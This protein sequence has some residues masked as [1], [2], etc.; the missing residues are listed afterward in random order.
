MSASRANAGAKNRRAGGAGLD[1]RPQQ[2]EPQQ[3]QQP[4]LSISDAIG[5]ITLRLGRVENV[6]QH[7]QTDLPKSEAT[8]LAT[9]T[10]YV[11]QSAFTAITKRLEAIEQKQK[12]AIVPAPVLAPAPVPFSLPE[13]LVTRETVEKLENELKEVKEILLKLQSFTM[14]VNGK[15]VTALFDNSKEEAKEQDYGEQDNVQMSQMFGNQFD[16]GS[17]LQAISRQ[18]PAEDNEK[19]IELS[20][21]NITDEFNSHEI[22]ELHD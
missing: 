22:E 8:S 2:A 4:K 15:L 12:T 17:F 6:V 11:D 21:P 5:L 19:I 20:G 14:D 16:L 3:V 9:P 13:N 7:L 1:I 18:Q 10:N